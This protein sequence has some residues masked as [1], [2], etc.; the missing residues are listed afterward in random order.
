[1][2]FPLSVSLSLSIVF[3]GLTNTLFSLFCGFLITEQ[4]FPTF[5]LFMYW[6]DPF[7]YVLEA[8]ITAM[9]HKDTTEIVLLNHMKTTAETFVKD[10]QYASWSYG[11]IGYD[12]LALGLFIT[13]AM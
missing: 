9:F 7:H 6:L 1:M 12:A 13:V 11:H 5:W 8:L 4:A 3:A 10:Y 2:S